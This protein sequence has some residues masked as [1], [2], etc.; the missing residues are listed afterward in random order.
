[1]EGLQYEGLLIL[2]D[3]SFIHCHHFMCPSIRLIAEHL[4]IAFPCCFLTVLPP[5]FMPPL[6]SLCRFKY[7][8]TPPDKSLLHVS[9][10]TSHSLFSSQLF[11][12]CPL[13]FPSC[14]GFPPTSSLSLAVADAASQFSPGSGLLASLVEQWVAGGVQVFDLH[15]VV[16][17][18]HGGQSTGHLLLQHTERKGLGRKGGWAIEKREKKNQS[19]GGFI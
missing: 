14:S 1:M 3:K 4:Q 15:L 2:A 5:S 6:F 10:Q 16:I 8:H 18:T 7:E 9:A 11:Q 13:G 17:H 12:V 19:E